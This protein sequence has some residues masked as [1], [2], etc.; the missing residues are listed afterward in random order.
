MA[1][2]KA[3]KIKTAVVRRLAKELSVYEKEHAAEVER[4]EKLRAAAADASDLKHQ[5]RCRFFFPHFEA[6]CRRSCPPIPVPPPPQRS[7]P[8]GPPLRSSC[9]LHNNRRT[10][11]R[12]RR[13]WCPTADGGW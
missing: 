1:E 13:R 11:W 2:A 7:P 4:T 10:C 6:R 3:L 12:S 9:L 5:A 8:R